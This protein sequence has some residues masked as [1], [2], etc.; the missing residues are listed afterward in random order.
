LIGHVAGTALFHQPDSGP[1]SRGTV[2]GTLLAGLIGAS[3]LVPGLAIA[4]IGDVGVQPAIPLL[5]VYLLFVTMRRLPLPLQPLLWVMFILIAYAA[6]TMF[7]VSPATSMLYAGLQG[8]Y[9]LLGGVAFA[10]IC[11][12]AQHRQAFARGYMTSALVS[13]IV[14]FG[15]AA[16]STL[17]GDTIT[18]ANN[19]NFS[20]VDAYGRGAAFTPESSVLA[21]LLIP[22]LLCCWFERQGEGRVLASWQRGWLP[23]AILIVGLLATKSTSLFY[24]PALFAA[25]SALQCRSIRDFV[26]GLV[27]MLVLAIAAG[28]IFLHFYSSRLSDNDASSSEAWRA[29]KIFAGISIF[30]AHPVTGAGI[31]LVSDSGFFAPYMNVPA[32]LRW[33]DEPRKGVDSTVVRILAESGLAGFAAT[34]YPVFLFFRRSRALFQS[35]AFNGIGGLSYG[36]LFT[37][38]FISGYRDQIALL[39]P[40]VAFA[41]AANALGFIRP[42]AGRHR[43]TPADFGPLSPTFNPASLDRAGFNQ[44]SIW[45]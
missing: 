26:K 31:G 44:G 2:T 11:S 9:L 12:T 20:I 35:P 34:Y 45:R 14:A 17:S 7:S 19:S 40:M 36:L 8:T 32:D 39:L 3:C 16:Y 38:A 18:L 10:V 4:T 24:L 42:V 28:G 27:G 37:Q 41:V 1:Q 22:A 43:G 21:G 23:L 5:A 30:E 15:Q 13:S 25:V 6:A 29:T 33:N